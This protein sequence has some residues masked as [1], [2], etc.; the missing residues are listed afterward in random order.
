M[1]AAIH[2]KSHAVLKHFRKTPAALAVYW[3][4]IAR[5][6]DDS[7]AWPSLAGLARDTGWNKDT[8]QE[9]REF[10]VKHHALQRVLN[11]VRPAWRGLDSKKQ[12]RQL[13]LDRSEYYHPTGYIDIGGKRHWMLYFGGKAESGIDEPASFEGEKDD[14]L[15]RRTS[16]PSDVG[17]GLISD[18]ADVRRHRTELNTSIELDSKTQEDNSQS[19]EIEERVTEVLTR[20]K[21][22]SINFSKAQFKKRQ[23]LIA[24][25][26]EKY[27][28]KTVVMAVQD[29]KNENAKWWSYVTNK[30]KAQRPVVLTGED[31]LSGEYG[32]LMDH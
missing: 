32:Y 24:D 15:P 14:V 26:I 2:G 4:Y 12:K 13:N 29:A 30:L 27:G 7:V 9:A 5:S 6:N 8:C 3:I 23:T 18:G 31:Y 19:S 22:A 20:L 10:L 21:M 16:K 25:A 28:Y 11:Y 1:R 17:W